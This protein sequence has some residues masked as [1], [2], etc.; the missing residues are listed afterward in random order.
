MR[1]GRLASE[2][3][4]A[5]VRVEGEHWIWTGKPQFRMASAGASRH[6]PGRAALL[7][8]GP[9]FIPKGANVERA[10]DRHGCVRPEHQ[11]I[12]KRLPDPR[13]VAAVVVD[14][15]AGRVDARAAAQIVGV[16]RETMNRALKKRLP[17]DVRSARHRANQRGTV[18]HLTAAD[19]RRARGL[20]AAGGWTL[21]AIAREVGTSWRNIWLIVHRKTWKDVA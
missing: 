18:A 6:A 12:V 5:H 1:E 2:R 20:H 3:F 11:R 17:A 10:C 9:A 4:M 8:F 15:A 16:H 7:L 19:V 13:L 21:A 14:Y